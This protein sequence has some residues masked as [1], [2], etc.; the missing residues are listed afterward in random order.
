MNE[1]ENQ[2]EVDEGQPEFSDVLGHT[3]GPWSIA[4]SQYINRL[5]INPTI[6]EVYG[7]GSELAANAALVAAA[8]D[9]LAALE[10]LAKLG[11]EPHY[12]NSIGNQIARDAIAAVMGHNINYAPKQ[13]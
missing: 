4:P 10:K 1:P 13:D 6:G 2:N 8:P 3:P 7:S 11:N 12:G 9:L 5:A